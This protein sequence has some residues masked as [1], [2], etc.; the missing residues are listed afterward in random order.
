MPFKTTVSGEL[1]SGVSDFSLRAKWTVVGSRTIPSVRPLRQPPT[2][3]SLEKAIDG[4][5]EGR[6]LSKTLEEE[7]R[8]KE[9]GQIKTP[10]TVAVASTAWRRST[11]V[12][13]TKSNV[14][15]SK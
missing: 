5:E 15:E 12:T 11:C 9:G 1:S 2:A 10:P 8:E 14:F 6:A 3:R 13:L 7:K 4:S